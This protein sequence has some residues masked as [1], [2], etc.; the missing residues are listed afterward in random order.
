MLIGGSDS[1][2]LSGIQADIAVCS[3]YAVKYSNITTSI[4]IQ[5]QENFYNRFDQDATFIYDNILNLIDKN[6]IKYVKIGMIGNINI[7]KKIVDIFADTNHK[8]ILD[9]VIYSSSGGELLDPDATEYLKESILPICYLI[10]PNINEIEI[11]TNIKIKDKADM[12]KAATILKNKGCENVIIKGGHLE[13]NIYSIDLLYQDKENIYF[14]EMARLD[15]NLRGTGCRFATSISCN[16]ILGK[17]LVES[18]KIS[19]Q[20]VTRLI[21]QKHLKTESY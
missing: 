11:L 9:P 12:I 13:N 7:A 8:L 19:K 21:A 10:T 16:Q 18:F 2:A 20:Y 15:N 5:D 14:E 17:S 1:S 4:T 6:N 3:H